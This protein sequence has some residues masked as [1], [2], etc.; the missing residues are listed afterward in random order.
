M[1]DIYRKLSNHTNCIIR[2]LSSTTAVDRI[3]RDEG[4]ICSTPSVRAYD[5]TA[6]DSKLDFSTFLFAIIS[7][8]KFPGLVKQFL[9]VEKSILKTT[10][11]L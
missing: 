8:K 1:Y 5:T 2:I 4:S 7:K 3:I 9:K 6:I 10:N 11:F